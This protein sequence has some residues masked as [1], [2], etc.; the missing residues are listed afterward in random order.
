M[1]KSFTF[2]QEINWYCHPARKAKLLYWQNPKVGCSSI[3]KSLWKNE[4]GSAPGNAHIR[5]QSPFPLMSSENSCEFKDF[6]LFTYVR[7]PFSRI[8]SAY[9]DKIGKGSDRHIW[10]PFCQQ[11]S[12]PRATTKE[13]FSFK[14]FLKKIR[15]THPSNL[16]PHFRPQFNGLL[17]HV[18]S[19]D[20][21]GF[22]ETKGSIEEFLSSHSVDYV[23]SAPHSRGS[24]KKIGDY[25]SQE[26]VDLVLDIYEKD[27]DHFGYSTALSDYASPGKLTSLANSG[28]V[29]PS[30]IFEDFEGFLNRDA[31]EPHS[32]SFHKLS[33]FDSDRR[34][35]EFL[36]GFIKNCGAINSSVFIKE[37][38]NIL[39]ANHELATMKLLLE[40]V[41]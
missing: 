40:R 30:Q 16:D 3:K 4:S 32:S 26:E 22:L 9:L 27:F 24:N 34:K 18:L 31:I 41:D 2:Q 13:Q 6:K 14:D 37:A 8:L 1:N 39:N 17:P 11:F 19:Y 33:S 5:G 36:K 10:R 12:L 35:V 15:S 25:Y 7:N 28:L 38:I 23:H 21:I 20:F 29:H